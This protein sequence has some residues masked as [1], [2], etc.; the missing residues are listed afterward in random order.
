MHIISLSRFIMKFKLFASLGMLAAV[1]VPNA[2]A[3]FVDITGSANAEAILYVQEAGIV[4]GYADGTYKPTSS[5]NRAEFTKIVVGSIEGMDLMAGA[6]CFS[7]IDAK[8]WYASYVCTA[9]AKGVIGGY[10]DGTF[11][12]ADPVNYAEAAKIV[13]EANGMQKMN[14]GDQWFDGYIMALAEANSNLN[15]QPSALLTRGQMAQ[16]IFN[17]HAQMNMI[18]EDMDN[19]DMNN[20]VGV[21]VG[22]AL[23]VE[24]KNIVE[25]AANANNLTT[26]VAAVQAAG[27]VDTLSG[28]GPFTVFAPTNSAFAALP[29]GTVDTL[30]MTENKGAL[31]DIL[32]Y[33]V[34]SGTYASTDL[35]DGMILETVQG[36]ELTIK[37][38]GN[39]WFVNDAKI[40]IANAKSSN[41][42][43]FVIDS[44]LMP[45]AE[46]N[47]KGYVDYSADLMNDG[48]STVLFF[49][50]SWCPSCQAD[51]ALLTQLD[52]DADFMYNV[53]KVDYDTATELK[54]QY[55]VTTQHTYVLVDAEGKLVQ[56]WVG[57][58]DE[59]VTELVTV[60][61]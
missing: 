47:A 11:K 20:E 52:A 27:L 24:S 3:A 1:L 35:E 16:L 32:T 12:P 58:S 8:A 51:D 54:A 45:E 17:L 26:L 13:V 18:D 33:H 42:T 4:E 36:G 25:N 50:A 55:G 10:P 9:K 57:P 7:D 23:M 49:H 30:L 53:A 28:P 6:T 46:M 56:K 29:A 22:G 59:E 34:V 43:A 60:G 61:M 5:I 15:L 40:L 48:M 21:E 14:G 44:V 31:A 39:A 19:D 37:Y 41:G 2:Q 38:D